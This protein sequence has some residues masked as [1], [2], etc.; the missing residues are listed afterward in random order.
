[1]RNQ[2][3]EFGNSQ[4]VILRNGEGSNDSFHEEEHLT[5]A[6]LILESA[7]KERFTTTLERLA[8]GGFDEVEEASLD[9]DIV[10]DEVQEDEASSDEENKIEDASEDPGVDTVQPEEM[11]NTAKIETLSQ[12][13]KTAQEK[14]ATLEKNSISREELMELLLIISEI[15]KAENEEEKIGLFELLVMAMTKMLT[16]LVTDEHETQKQSSSR[17]VFQPKK[18]ISF[19]EAR[20]RLVKKGLLNPQRPQTINQAA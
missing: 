14:I 4:S 10:P 20:D 1:M 2:S 18:V 9:A 6:D 3:S 7:K 11:E 15:N 8:D 19:A 17:P 5:C 16:E 13:L 12:E